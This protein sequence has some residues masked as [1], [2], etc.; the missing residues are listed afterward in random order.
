MGRLIVTVRFTGVN[1]TSNPR[2]DHYGMLISGSIVTCCTFYFCNVINMHTFGE[3][4]SICKYVSVAIN[5]YD[6][7]TSKKITISLV[8]ENY[9]I[10]L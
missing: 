9:E 10:S 4:K 8:S 3:E 1:S 5:S 7:S 2:V 6:D